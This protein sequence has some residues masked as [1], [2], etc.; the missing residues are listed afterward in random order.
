MTLSIPKQRNI[1]NEIQRIVNACEV[2]NGYEARVK[3]Y[4]VKDNANPA[5]IL[6]GY[7]IQRLTLEFFNVTIED[8]MNKGKKRK[9]VISDIRYLMGYLLNI[10]TPLTLMRITKLLGGLDGDHTLA[11]ESI[12]MVKVLVNDA[13]FLVKK[14]ELENYILLN[15]KF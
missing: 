12:A 8:L 6:K 13:E 3:L 14:I 5:A 4:R 10:H 9:R 2:P 7:E 15:L 1:T 11:H